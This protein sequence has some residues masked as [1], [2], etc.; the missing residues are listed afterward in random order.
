MTVPIETSRVSYA[1]NGV[2]TVFSTQFYFLE[3]SDLRVVSISGLGVET[4]LALGVN[5]SVTMPASVGAAGSITMLSGA[6]AVGETLRIERDVM[7]VQDASFRTQGSFS[8]AVHEDAMDRLMFGIQEL[9]RRVGDLES[10]GAPG[11]VVAG[12]GLFFT[13]VNLH[14][15]A[16]A[17]VVVNA[18]DVAVDFGVTADMA[19]V[20]ST[21][22]DA[23]SMDKAARVDHKHD[24]E[25]GVPN[26]LV[27]GDTALEGSST[28]VALADHTHGVPVGAPVDLDAGAKATGSA[29]TFS[30][31]DH[32]HTITTG[33]PVDITDATNASGAATSLAR[34]NHQHAHGNRGGGTLHAVATAVAA[35][36]MPASIFDALSAILASKSHVHAFQGAAQS[37]PTGAGGANCIFGTEDYDADAEYD[38][39]TGIFTAK[40]AG[41]LLVTLNYSLASVAW[42]ATNAISLGIIRNN[43]ADITEATVTDVIDAA[44]TRP[45]SLHV[46]KV[47]RVA[48]AGET[49]RG[50]LAHNQGGAVNSGG[51]RATCSLTIH[52]IL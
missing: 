42:A 35:G 52:R 28:S 34:S 1:G 18:N 17:G 50:V 25:S 32:K 6:P 7:L 2:T 47:V 29:G 43:G 21:V 48:A 40:A 13:G 38:P 26:D 14:A 51:T 46:A 49:I 15:G 23:G 11:S 10:A 20:S 24:I 41:Y 9:D 44:V 4:T 27:V 8:P 22:A 19:K 39:A 30:D 3:E 37:M 12:D 36:F 5:Y 31:S 33:V 45:V 16:G